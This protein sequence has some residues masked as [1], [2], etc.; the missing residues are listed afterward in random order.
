[1]TH[2]HKPRKG[3]FRELNTK[4]VLGEH[5]WITTPGN[6]FD[7]L[8][9]QL[10][11]W[12]SPGG[13]GGYLGWFLLGMCRW[14]LSEPLLHYSLFCGQLYIDPILVTFGQ[15]CNFR[16]PNLVTF[17]LCIYLILNEDHFTFHIQYKHS[18]TFANRQYEE[19]SYTKNQ[20]MCDPILVTLLKMRSYYSQS[21][22]EN[23]TPSSGTSPSASYE[24]VLPPRGMGAH[25]LHKFT[26]RVEILSILH[27]TRLNY[28]IWRGGWRPATKNIQIS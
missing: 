15:T 23:A 16:D 25:H 21:S 17:Y 24:K 5:E 20:K 12:V 27:K 19:L 6:F 18:G 11:P 22:H 7:F 10:S 3:D 14:A 2:D 26:T 9:Q 8:L 4:N 13:W 28:E 1:M